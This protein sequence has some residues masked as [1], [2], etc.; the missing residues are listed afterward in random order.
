[1][2]IPG[3]TKAPA[4]LVPW[5]PPSMVK[6]LGSN[7][8]LL[9]YENVCHCVHV[10]PYSRHRLRSMRC[11]E[12]KPVSTDRLAD[13]Q[14]CT[15]EHTRSRTLKDHSKTILIRAVHCHTAHFFLVS[16]SLACWLQWTREVKAWQ[17]RSRRCL[18][19]STSHGMAKL[20]FWNFNRLLPVRISL[21]R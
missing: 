13:C 12:K 21:C 10:Q 2:E 4:D 18:K 19:R 11:W 20:R 3:R 14:A 5:Q 8:C 17:T 1:M 6:G 7:S 9:N 16:L 15:R